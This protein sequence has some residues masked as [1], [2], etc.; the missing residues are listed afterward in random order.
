MVKTFQ[1][2]ES[3]EVH[4]HFDKCYKLALKTIE[5]NFK[6]ISQQEKLGR[7][8]GKGSWGWSYPPK[9]TVQIIKMNL[10]SSKMN[11]QV[12]ASGG[13]LFSPNTSKQ[14]LDKF[15]EKFNENLSL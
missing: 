4:L 6:L 15:I 13:G 11:V 12:T 10:S 2:Q 8:E 1:E 3:L 7:I 9:I 14:A 5:E